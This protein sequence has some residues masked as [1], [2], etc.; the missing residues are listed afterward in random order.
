MPARRSTV[1]VQDAHALTL[2]SRGHARFG[3]WCPCRLT[4]GAGCDV[5]GDPDEVSTSLGITSDADGG[6]GTSSK[7][8]AEHRDLAGIVSTGVNVRHRSIVSA[9]P[10]RP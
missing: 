8:E 2:A 5:A 1:A 4:S 7:C 10:P 9:P 3:D 6:N